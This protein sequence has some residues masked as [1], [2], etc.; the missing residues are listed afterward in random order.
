M[1]GVNQRWLALVCYCAQLCQRSQH[2]VINERH[3]A[4]AA[5]GLLRGLL[6]RLL[7]GCCEG[8]SRYCCSVCRILSILCKLGTS[9][10]NPNCLSRLSALMARSVFIHCTEHNNVCAVSSVQCVQCHSAVCSLVQCHSVVCSV[11][12]FSVFTDTGQCVQ[13]VQCSV[14]SATVQCVQ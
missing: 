3:Y 11:P 9:F 8:C 7:R 13:Y 1:P 12:P 4:E 2:A 10:M 5:E 6:R 14:F